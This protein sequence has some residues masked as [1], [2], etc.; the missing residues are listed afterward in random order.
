MC[1]RIADAPLAFKDVIPQRVI[2]F[3]AVARSGSELASITGNI[4]M[5][6]RH[7]TPDLTDKGV[8]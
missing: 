4:E 3:G 2:R 8:I 5:L 1:Q 6:V 7:L